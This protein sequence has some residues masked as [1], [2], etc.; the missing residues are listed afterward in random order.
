VVIENFP[1]GALQRYGL[2]HAS[3]C[4]ADP[5]LVYVSSTGFGQTGPYAR[6]KGYDTIFQA[7][8]GLMSLTG[9]REGG[10]VK[11]GLPVADLTSGLWLAIGVLAM[12]MGRAQ[13]GTG[14]HLD[15]A[16]L[17]GQVSLLTLAAAR[18]F[19]LGEVP[20]RLGTEHPGRVPSAA[21]QCRDGNWLHITGSDQHWAGLC[22]VLALADLAADPALADNAG[23]VRERE[24][25]MAQLRAAVADWD[26]DALV[27]ACLAADVP[28]GPVNAVDQVLADPQVRARGMVDAFDHPTVGRFPALPLPFKFS[29]FD[30]PQLGRPPLLGEHTDALL[31]GLG[32]A[33]DAIARLRAAKVVS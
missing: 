16:M 7:M 32:F 17:D 27:D 23:R 6:R 10:P 33:P 2:D 24:R 14:G 22:R 20:P 4:A 1:V 30:S 15:F 29:G 11:P 28:A 26:R 13:T 12:L 8:G 18:L 21:F 5:R 3:L 19:A 25:V 31:A 9:E